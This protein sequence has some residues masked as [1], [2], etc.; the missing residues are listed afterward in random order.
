M[1]IDPTGVMNTLMTTSSST[2]TASAAAASIAAINYVTEPNK[3]DKKQTPQPH[4]DRVRK[5]GIATSIGS[6]ATSLTHICNP[7]KYMQMSR[8][9]TTTYLES[10]NDEQ[11]ASLEKM[12]SEK[13]D[14]MGVEISNIENVTQKVKKL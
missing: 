13:E 12:L 4:P 3:G 11:L 2:S 8:V 5:L 1:H 7:L 14:N 10:L 6:S 9:E